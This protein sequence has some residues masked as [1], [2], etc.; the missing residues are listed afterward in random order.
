[1]VQKK[2]RLMAVRTKVVTTQAMITLRRE[3][4]ILALKGQA[5]LMTLSIVI[6]ETV[7]D[8]KCLNR[9]FR[10]KNTLQPPL[11]N[12]VKSTHSSVRALIH[13][14]NNPPLNTPVSTIAKVLNIKPVEV[15]LK[16]GACRTINDTKLP[17]VPKMIIKG[18]T[19][20]SSFMRS[21]YCQ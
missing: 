12:P 2:C 19:H 8:D 4:I 11:D 6:S 7:M 18:E 14:I 1:M 21:W 3:Q 20:R 16:V 13:N 5:T 10:K 15:F 9:V 17:T